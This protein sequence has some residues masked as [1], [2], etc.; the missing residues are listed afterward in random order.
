MATWKLLSA[1]PAPGGQ[2][3]DGTPPGITV[4]CG[5]VVTADGCFCTGVWFRATDTVDADTTFTIE[6]WQYA[7]GSTNTGTRLAV[8]AFDD[9]EITAGV[10]QELSFSSPVALDQAERYAASVN[11]GNASTVRYCATGGGFTTGETQGPL[12]GWADSTTVLGVAVMRN[13]VF[14][15]GSAPGSGSFPGSAFG[16]PS[17]SVSPI[18]DDGE[19]GET[20]SGS[21]AIGL[22]LDVAGA[23]SKVGQGIGALDLQLTI[24]AS[25][26]KKARGAGAIGLALAMVAGPD[27]QFYVPAKLTARARSTALT[28]RGARNLTARGGYPDA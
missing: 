26:R 16:S 2:H 4:A 21:G 10:W 17:Y 15:D 6:L 12:T 24:A 23:G 14:R 5:F 28:A 7:A 22:A 18:V 13:N 27:A 9:S 20:H 11:Y 25:G 8:R 1:G 3:A 19:G